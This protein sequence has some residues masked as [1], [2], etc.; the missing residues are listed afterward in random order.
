MDLL[1]LLMIALAQADINMLVYSTPGV[2]IVSPSDYNY[3]AELIAELYGGG[4]GGADCIGYGGGAGGYLKAR[5][6]S[7]KSQLYINVGYG[8]EGGSYPCD[9]L[10]P[11]TCSNG[12]YGENSF[13]GVDYSRTYL[14]ADGGYPTLGNDRDGYIPGSGGSTACYYCDAIAQGRGG[15]GVI[16]ECTGGICQ[17]PILPTDVGSPVGGNGGTAAYGGAGGYGSC[18]QKPSNGICIAVEGSMDGHSP[19]GGGGGY[20]R[21]SNNTTQC[22]DTVD[23]VSK[24][25]GRGANGLIIIYFER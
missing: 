20:F 11:D 1:T 17:C 13:I 15:D 5:F 10:G 18:S 2:Y 22:G 6:S 21:I 7:N 3:N 24:T 25:A 9:C 8:G 23:L 12:E 16:S 19:G 4:A 14:S